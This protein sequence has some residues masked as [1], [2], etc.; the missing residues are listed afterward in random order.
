MS[1]ILVKEIIR[2]ADH[3]EPN[4]IEEVVEQLQT[5]LNRNK[6]SPQE[7]RD[8]LDSLAFD[9]GEVLP[10]YSD[11]HEDWYSDDGR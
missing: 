7:F 4:E 9:V 10:A 8:W 2:M 1:D 3:L 5:R 6:L 11:R